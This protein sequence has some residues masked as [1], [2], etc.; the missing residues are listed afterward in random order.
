MLRFCS[1]F[2]GSSGNCT[3]IETDNAAILIDA[4]GS[5]KKIINQLEQINASFKKLRGI[6]ITHEHFDHI[7]G[8]KAIASKLKI[9]VMANADTLKA[10]WNSFPDMDERLF[11]PINNGEAVCSDDFE[12]CAFSTPHDGADS[13]GYKISIGDKTITVA[14][15]M[16][17]I[18]ESFMNAAKTSDI[19]LLEA[20]YDDDMLRCGPYPPFLKKRIA[21]KMGHLSNADAAQAVVHLVN[22][23]T[24]RILLG[25]LSQDN[26]TPKTA[27]T[28]VCDMLTKNGINPEKDILLKIA[29]RFDVSYVFEI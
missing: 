21:G 14:T 12:V 11:S 5:A 4:G 3:Y 2:S 25:H 23:G 22:S 26:N 7:S 19:V 1:L 15:D 28:A 16:G 10:I 13:V 6:F 20:N 17:Y 29:P 9:P 27:N 18:S 24:G 8:V